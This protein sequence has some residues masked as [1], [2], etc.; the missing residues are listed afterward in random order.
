MLESFGLDGL[1]RTSPLHCHSVADV[2]RFLLITQDLIAYQ[3]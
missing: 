1:V 2:D 3:R